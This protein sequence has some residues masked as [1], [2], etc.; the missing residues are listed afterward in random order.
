M[1]PWMRLASLGITSTSM[2]SD[3]RRLASVF[4]DGQGF[5]GG[6]AGFAWL[7]RAALAVGDQSDTR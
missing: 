6:F 1:V 2:R 4:A 7:L 3:G 5:A